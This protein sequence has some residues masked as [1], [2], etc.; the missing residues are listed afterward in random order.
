[1]PTTVLAALVANGVYPDPYFGTNINK[2]PGAIT[3]RNREM[4]EG[5]PFRVPW[6]YCTE[7][8]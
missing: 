8:R 4:P 3:G 7:F 1:M 6:W 5:S 2:I